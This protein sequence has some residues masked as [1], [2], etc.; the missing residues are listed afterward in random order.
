MAL[1]LLIQQFPD[2]VA[3]KVAFH[4]NHFRPSPHCR[5]HPSWAFRFG[6]SLLRYS[7][8]MTDTVTDPII[9]NGRR[10][11]RSLNRSVFGTE[12]RKPDSSLDL[13]LC[14][15]QSSVLVFLNL[16]L[17][18]LLELVNKTSFYNRIPL[19]KIGDIW[20][21]VKS[22]KGGGNVQ[23]MAFCSY[24]MWFTHVKRVQ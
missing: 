4:F 24:W 18:L 17:L 6:F 13:V 1:F 23:T 3:V 19:Q 12:K 8:E 14:S 9:V 2:K 21:P 7:V 15:A 11:C 16:I 10:L 22:G 5:Q 20:Q